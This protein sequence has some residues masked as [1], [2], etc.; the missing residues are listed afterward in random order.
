MLRVLSILVIS[1][2]A[3]A[4]IDSSDASARD[5]ASGQAS[6]KRQYKPIVVTKQTNKASS[7]LMTKQTGP[8]QTGAS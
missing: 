5:I 7:K 2:F 3:V 8:T 1:L 6:G 4:V